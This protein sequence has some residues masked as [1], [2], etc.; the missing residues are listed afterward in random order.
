MKKL[1]WF[2]IAVFV[3][4]GGIELFLWMRY[5]KYSDHSCLTKLRIVNVLDEALFKDAHIKSVPGV[6]SINVPFEKVKEVAQSWQRDIPVVFYCSNYMCM[7]S[8]DSVKTLAEMGFKTVKAYEGGMAEWYQLGHTDSL[9]QTEGDARLDY[10]KYEAKAP[11]DKKDYV[12]SAQELQKMIKQASLLSEA[13][14]GACSCRS[15]GCVA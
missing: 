8:G 14:N 15:C 1:I 2:L 12:V 10:L 4:G 7:A 9:Y 6:E 3:F 11:E 5:K 13:N